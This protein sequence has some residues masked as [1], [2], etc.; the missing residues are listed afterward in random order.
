MPRN[1]N[2]SQIALQVTHD[3]HSLIKTAATAQPTDMAE[4]IR[5][6]IRE[7]LARD[8]YDVP[9][10]EIEPRTKHGKRRGKH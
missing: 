8:G 3:L 7:K 10:P 9:E 1:P 2:K 5:Q 6:A 4:Y